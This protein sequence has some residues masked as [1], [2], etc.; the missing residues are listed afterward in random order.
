MEIVRA[1]LSP[2][3]PARGSARAVEMAFP[4]RLLWKT[5]VIT[6]TAGLIIV[7]SC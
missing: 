4:P 5:Q 2:E 3:Q 1:I 7:T 6:S